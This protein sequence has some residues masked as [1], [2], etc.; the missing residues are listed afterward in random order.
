MAKPISH[1]PRPARIGPD[2]HEEL[3]RLLQTAHEHGVLRFANDL[4]AADAQWSRVIVEGL[5][6]P[7]ARNAVQNLG[8]L[9]LVLSRIEPSQMYK[10]A[11]ALKA[12]G[13]HLDRSA[14]ASTAESPGVT[15]AYRMLHDDSIWSAVT[16]L[17]EALQVF[18]ASLNRPVDHP[19]SEFTGK[20][21][22]D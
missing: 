9:A 2:A 12:A 5:N 15:G 21:T 7:G 16:P 18:V 11:F 1:Q 20:H 22:E 13:E 4:I 3:E 6:G 19:I 8:V 14:A 10:T 17:L